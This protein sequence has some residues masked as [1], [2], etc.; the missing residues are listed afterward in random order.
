MQSRGRPT[1]KPTKPQRDKV[2]LLIGFM[3][4]VAIASVLSIDHKTLRKHFAF[5][6]ENGRA[7]TVAENLAR[8]KK[9]AKAGNVTAMKYLDSKLDL[10]PEKQ[11]R[12]EPIGKKEQLA[13]DAISGHKDTEWGDVLQ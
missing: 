5:E 9:A 6:L 7:I 12:P 10:A 4:E 13:S 2:K 1:F 8:L 3:S 11:P